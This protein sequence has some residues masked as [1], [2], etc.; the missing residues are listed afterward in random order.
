MSKVT[1]VPEDKVSEII[2]DFIELNKCTKITAEKQPD[3]SWTI[4]GEP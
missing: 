2:K 1:D 4:T 3:G